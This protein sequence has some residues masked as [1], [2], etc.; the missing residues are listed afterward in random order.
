MFALT[1]VA[2]VLEYTGCNIVFNQVCHFTQ[3]SLIMYGE[4]V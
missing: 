1:V 2:F 4:V 3:Q